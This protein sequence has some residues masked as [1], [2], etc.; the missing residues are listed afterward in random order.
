[1][2]E[3]KITDVKGEVAGLLVLAGCL[4]WYLGYKTAKWA[5]LNTV[6]FGMF[7]LVSLGVLAMLIVRGRALYQALQR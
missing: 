4:G 3:V 2:F 6:E 5:N 1:M 7:D